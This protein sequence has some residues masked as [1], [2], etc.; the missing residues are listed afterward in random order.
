[1]KVLEFAF[2]A[3]PVTDLQRARAFYE[4]VLGFTRESSP[5]D[6]EAKWFEY[7]VGPHTLG[8]GSHPTFK[9]SPDGPTLALEVEDF[10]ATIAH[11]KAHQVS[12][13][14]EAF[15]TPV[16]HMAFIF[17]PDG[18]KLCIHQRKG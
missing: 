6:A 3:Y 1:M 17:D 5:K 8:I 16:C 4:D 12:F 15:E 11:L 14:T 18:N 9:P 7:E 10:G 13:Q 2:V